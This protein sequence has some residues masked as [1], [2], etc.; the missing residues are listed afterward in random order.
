MH[1]FDDQ[2]LHYCDKGVAFLVNNADQSCK[3]SRARVEGSNHLPMGMLWSSSYD[4][5]C[6]SRNTF[7]Q[8]DPSLGPSCPSLS[9]QCLHQELRPQERLP[10]P[11]RGCSAPWHRGM[12]F[13]TCMRP[14]IRMLR[15]DSFLGGLNYSYSLTIVQPY[16]LTKYEGNRFVGG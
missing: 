6:M 16:S 15:S 14:W 13:C 5:C 3:F 2:R 4:H 7:R 1:S 10:R 8:P 11:S 12:H 9:R